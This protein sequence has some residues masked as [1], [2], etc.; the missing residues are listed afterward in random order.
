MLWSNKLV[1]PFDKRSDNQS[2][3]LQT[4]CS[5]VEQELWSFYITGRKTV[6]SD[7]LDFWG[8]SGSSHMRW[9]VV[10]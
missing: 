10:E 3:A 9:G 1:D 4:Q 7:F 6:N 8:Y 2:A 5:N